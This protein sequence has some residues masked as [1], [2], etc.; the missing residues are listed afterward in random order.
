MVPAADYTKAHPDRALLVIEV[1]DTSLQKDRGVKAALYATAGVPEFWLVNLTET[2][3]EVHRR[4]STG[5]Y[6]DIQRIDA[7]GTLIPEAF[8][9][10][11]IAAHEILG[12]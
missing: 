6:G 3:V 11:R 7:L 4:P 12:S 10:V 1:A 8:P 2:I 9:T 5:R